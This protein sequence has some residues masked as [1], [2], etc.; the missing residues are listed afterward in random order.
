M[1]RA[2]RP[3]PEEMREDE[4]DA[5]GCQLRHDGSGSDTSGL[6]HPSVAVAKA[7]E[8]DGEHADDV[9]LEQLPKALC[10]HSR[11]DSAHSL[12]KALGT[13]HSKALRTT[14]RCK[15]TMTFFRRLSAVEWQHH[16]TPDK[17]P[18]ELR[19]PLESQPCL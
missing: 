7:D 18:L 6:L 14:T 19:K 12:S 4:L 15:C 9:G 16:P 10:G 11:P 3:H 1:Y 5:V 8:Q 2:A 13:A 17:R